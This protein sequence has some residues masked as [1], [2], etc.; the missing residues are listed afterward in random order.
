MTE[1]LD[2]HRFGS[3]DTEIKLELVR[4]YLTS[5]S[6]ALGGKF[7][8]WYIDAFA[9][10]G[11]RT[12][13][14]LAREG[15]FVTTDSAEWVEKRPGSARIAL[16]IQPWFDRVTLMDSK[17][18]H[19]AA[20]E[21]LKAE[22]PGREI[23]IVS[24]DCNRF[25]Q[26]EIAKAD[27][28]GQRA[29]LFLDPYGMEVEWK[30]LTDIAAT[31][32]I[33]VW[34]LFSLEGLY[35]NAAHDIQDVDPAKRAAL[36]RMLGTDAWEHELYSEYLPPSDLFDETPAEERRRNLDVAGLEAYVTGRLRTV[37]PMV[38]EPYALPVQRKPQRFSLFCMISNDEPRAIGLARR[39]GDHILKAGK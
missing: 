38:L 24:G 36:T 11:S 23:E 16:E 9:G 14:H 12:I 2:E 28:S 18:R 30:T 27:W 37:F 39:I 3:D 33:D 15:D 32:S 31:R 17:P 22:Y 1:G 19:V 6:T 8:L 21:R 5:Y 4:R 34:Y 13:K 25:L 7:R 35:R 29:A 10:T 26:A 20:L